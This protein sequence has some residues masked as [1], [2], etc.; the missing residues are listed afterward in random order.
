VKDMDK[1]K[2]VRKGEEQDW[3]ALEAY[4]RATLT[5]ETKGNMEV[6]QFHGGHAN[7]TYLLKL[8]E[9]ELVIRRP[10]FGK[11]APGAHDMKREFR[12]LSK[13]HNFFPQAPKAYHYCE[14]ESI[15]G[16]PF[17]VLERK[18]GVVVRTHVIDCFKSDDNVAK[19]LT[20]ALVKVSA[21]LHKVD[22][23]KADLT[24]LGRPEG[25]L[26]RQLAGLD[27]R[28]SLVKTGNSNDM[29]DV[30]KLLTASIPTPQAISIIHNDLKLD[31]C[32][33]Q[34]DDPDQVTAVFDWDMTTLGDPLVDLGTTLSYWREPY[35]DEY[36]LPVYLSTEFPE[37][38]FLID[39][40]AEFTG[41]SMENIN[42]YH[43]FAFLRI[44]VIAAQLYQR[45]VN[46]KSTDQ[47]MKKFQHAADV[48]AAYA[49]KLMTE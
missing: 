47:R 4:L 30:I 14:N 32:Q 16:A 21:D 26:E 23:E 5:E 43:A 24:K 19:R 18:T 44:G 48:F 9:K 37:K 11:I 8:G 28:W 13:L 34:P 36:N 46:G 40:Y 15:I 45:Y 33:F 27:K 31:N 20:E 17:V 10:P 2:E 29:D 6:L 35:F 38:Q 7:L 25:F 42:W 12:V 1:A 22:Y 3:A 41:F 39:K 49:K